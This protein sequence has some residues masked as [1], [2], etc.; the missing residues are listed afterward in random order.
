MNT[1]FDHIL[2]Y[3]GLHKADYVISDEFYANVKG[4]R[5]RK[6]EAKV[7][8]I[9]SAVSTSENQMG[10]RFFVV[11]DDSYEWAE[12]TGVEY[13]ALDILRD[14][15]DALEIL[16]EDERGME[17]V[18]DTET[19]K[20]KITGKNFKVTRNN[21]NDIDEFLKILDAMD[22]IRWGDFYKRIKEAKHE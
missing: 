10:T 11:L 17:I 14:V 18:Y 13:K 2:N 21:V 4:P 15:N 19:C 3:V 6:I 7:Y 1:F 12:I 8:S 20:I 22:D 5:N 16:C 9:V